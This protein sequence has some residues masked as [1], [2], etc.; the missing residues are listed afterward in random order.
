M[1]RLVVIGAVLAAVTA[2]DVGARTSSSLELRGVLQGRFESITCPAG[3]APTTSCYRNELN[4]P[5]PGLGSVSIQHMLFVENADTE[6]ATWR[7][8]SAL[9]N[10][11]GEIRIAAKSTACIPY[12]ARAVRWT[13]R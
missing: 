1:K 7:A 3:T 6:C 5:V 13:S 10:A 2:G 12:G 11:K 8:A 4:G 9:T